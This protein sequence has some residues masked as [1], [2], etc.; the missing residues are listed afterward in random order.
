MIEVSNLN[1]E[2][3][4]AGV[5]GMKWGVRKD[6][7]KSANTL[8]RSRNTSNDTVTKIVQRG[9]KTTVTSR[10]AKS[11]AKLTVKRDRGAKLVAKNENIKLKVI[12][13]N[14]AS[15]A[16]GAL[17]VASAF[18][19]GLPI[20]NTVAAAANLVGIATTTR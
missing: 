7:T 13:S 11:K 2:L 8:R 16:S 20:L 5:K 14:T 15:I 10:N 4:H 9:D 19:P 3:Y 18:V 6:R 12:V 1:N 17:W